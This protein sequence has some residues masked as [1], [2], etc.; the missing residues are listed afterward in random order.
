[1]RTFLIL[2]TGEKLK[3][4]QPFRHALRIIR[5][6][7]RDFSRKQKGSKSRAKT[8]LV[9]ARAHRKV[10]NQR[11]AWHWVTAY[12]LVKRFDA[13]AFED[14]NIAGMRQLWGRTVSD[15]GFSS[16]LLK[17][18][19]LAE[20]YGRQFVRTPRFEPTTKRMS[21]CGHIQPVAL[22][23]IV[24]VCHGCGFIHDRDLNAA[25]N[26]Y[27]LGRQLWSGVERKTSQEAVHAITAESHRL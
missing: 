3:A 1:L 10:R 25:K 16:F 12:N 15:L 2:A 19:W 5:H 26:I 22:S 23:E 18:Q 9:L 20:K 7:S 24:V 11:T 13:L 21:C 27:E 14:L 17:Q 6:V 4:P 8:R